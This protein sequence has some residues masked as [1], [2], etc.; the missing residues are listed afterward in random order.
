[1]HPHT[2]EQIET[3]ER[4]N[5]VAG[6]TWYAVS[7]D[8]EDEYEIEVIGENNIKKKLTSGIMILISINDNEKELRYYL[9]GNE[10]FRQITFIYAALLRLQGNWM[11]L[12]MTSPASQGENIPANGAKSDDI[13]L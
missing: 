5:I 6:Y 13:I 1:M 12:W 2:E 4:N 9:L 8:N 7:E 11:Y 10:S 3:Y